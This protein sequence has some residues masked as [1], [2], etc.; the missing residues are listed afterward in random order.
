MI[1]QLTRSL[2]P[3]YGRLY[4]STASPKVLTEEKEA[5]D[6]NFDSFMDDLVQET[7]HTAPNDHAK[8]RKIYALS[9]QD[10]KTEFNLRPPR[11]EW[12]L[13][14]FLDYLVALNKKDKKIKYQEWLKSEELASSLHAK[15][16]SPEA[17]PNAVV[18]ALA[19]LLTLYC[20]PKDSEA[21]DGLVD[22]NVA[23]EK[24][25]SLV[26]EMVKTTPSKLDIHSLL[27]LLLASKHTVYKLPDGFRESI[28]QLLPKKIEDI[29]QPAVLLNI[30]EVDE[31]IKNNITLDKIEGKID[32]LL[33][34]M[35]TGELVSLFAVHVKVRRNVKTLS[36]IAEAIR[37]KGTLTAN[38]CGKLLTSMDLLSF[39]HPRLLAFVQNQISQS[40]HEITRWNVFNTIVYSLAKVKVNNPHLW[41]YLAQWTNSH[42]RTADVS[43]L[44]M[45]LSSLAMINIPPELVE[46][47][48]KKLAAILKTERARSPGVWLNTCYSLAMLRCLPA[49]FGETLLEL[50]FLSE[51]SKNCSEELRLFRV[52]KVFHVASY[53]KYD[54]NLDVKVP[55]DVLNLINSKPKE[56]LITMRHRKNVEAEVLNFNNNLFLIAP[57]ETHIKPPHIELNTGAYVDAVVYV[58]ETTKKLVPIKAAETRNDLTKVAIIYA[59]YNLLTK[60]DLDERAPVRLSGDIAMNVRHLQKAG[61]RTVVL[62]KHEMA[63]MTEGLEQAK[64]LKKAIQEGQELKLTPDLTVFQN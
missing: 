37:T 64:Y 31:L 6:V 45:V 35:N 52:I 16:M 49:R 15:L 47:S 5:E 58:D 38:Q 26:E 11:S 63:Q 55:Q 33:S 19:G 25:V 28:I 50:S 8:T 32:E 60:P 13:V 36:R 30:F 17:A 40:L 9:F 29:A 27:T 59:T 2:R 23:L 14:T 1:R 18:S 7:V 48:T 10:L 46:V 43:Q 62:T 54:L 22:L 24:I 42:A 56:M 3:F 21:S 20:P 44:S 34:I 57:K 4:Y 53:L 41:Y 39:Y 12:E 51:L 61:Y